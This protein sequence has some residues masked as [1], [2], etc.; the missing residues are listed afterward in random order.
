MPVRARSY[1]PS[2]TG[3]AF[4][5]WSVMPPRKPRAGDLRKAL[6]TSLSIAEALRKIG[7]VPAGGNYETVHR[8]IREQNIDVSHMTGQGWNK[9]DHSRTLANNRPTIPLEEILVNNSTY[10]GGSHTLKKRLLASGLKQWA[11]ERCYRHAW[12]GKPIPLELEHISGKRFDN[13]IE[14]LRLLCPNCHAQTPTYRGR[15]IGNGGWN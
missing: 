8:L 13:R 9:E 7:L 11:C 3:S 10:R 6:E 12:N 4:G 14:N 5:D 2:S 1:D 15:N